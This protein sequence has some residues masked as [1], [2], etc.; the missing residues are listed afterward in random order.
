MKSGGIAPPSLTLVLDVGEW[1]A[2]CLCF[3]NPGERAPGTHCIGGWISPNVGL[4]AVEKRKILYC[5]ESNLGHPAF[6]P[7]AIPSELSRPPLYIYI[8]IYIY[9][10]IS[11][12]CSD[13]GNSGLM[14]SV[15]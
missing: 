4:D 13:V 7:V 12:L 9:A 1:S 2:S 15:R 5:R 14:C 11:I 6:K 10:H 8:Y 3:F